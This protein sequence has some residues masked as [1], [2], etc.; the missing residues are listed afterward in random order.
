MLDLVR[1]GLGGLIRQ[2]FFNIFCLAACPLGRGN[3]AQLGV[4][5]FGGLDSTVVFFSRFL[6]T[7]HGLAGEVLLDLVRFDFGVLFSQVGTQ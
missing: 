7:A 2:S 6:Q 3:G 5:W 4:S 1:L